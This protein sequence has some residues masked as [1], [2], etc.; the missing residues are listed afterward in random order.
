MRDLG[1]ARPPRTV[2]TKS[3]TN[4]SQILSIWRERTTKNESFFE[5]VYHAGVGIGCAFRR[6]R[7][8]T[9]HSV[10]CSS[11]I[12]IGL[13]FQ[14]DFMHWAVTAM[15]IGLLIASELIN[16]AVE[17]LVDLAA[18][19][20]FDQLA[21]EAKDIAAGAVLFCGVSLIVVGCCLCLSTEKGAG[22]LATMQSGNSVRHEH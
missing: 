4:V 21:R 17:R 20:S 6:E 7:L 19:S 2:V 10:I 22:W 1:V 9:I 16:T 18:G 13:I 14:F 3:Q 5:A 12:V 15:G 8:L 11:F